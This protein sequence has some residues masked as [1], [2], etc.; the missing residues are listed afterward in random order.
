MN[1]QLAF[2][3]SH[4]H[5]PLVEIIAELIH[6]RGENQLGFICEKLDRYEEPRK[7]IAVPSDSTEAPHN[8]QDLD[9]IFHSLP[10]MKPF[11]QD[12]VRRALMNLQGNSC[13][14]QIEHIATWF[15][16]ECSQ[17]VNDF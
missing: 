14:S 13:E 1:D 15:E 2:I 8:S 3:Y 11:L 4:V 6:I 16:S 17:F 10:A 7:Q 5:G 9:P 12:M